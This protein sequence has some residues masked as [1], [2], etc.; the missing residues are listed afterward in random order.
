MARFDTVPTG[1]IPLSPVLSLSLLL[2]ASIFLPLDCSFQSNPMAPLRSFRILSELSQ[3][4]R[5]QL[6]SKSDYSDEMFAIQFQSTRYSKLS[7]YN[8]E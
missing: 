4:L 8:Q 6:K 1:K 3:Q 7:G 5:E 2:S